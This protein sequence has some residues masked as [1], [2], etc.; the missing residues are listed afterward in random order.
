L[1]DIP[2]QAISIAAEALNDALPGG[3]ILDD[4]PA[5]RAVDRALQAAMPYLRLTAAQRILEL[6]LLGAD[7]L[8][9]FVRRDD[10]HRARAGQVQ[11]AKW[12]KTLQG[13]QP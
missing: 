8:A 1:A 2:A 13:D 10:G 11:I 7:I 12:Q 5:R 4:G 9:T 3:L 6:E